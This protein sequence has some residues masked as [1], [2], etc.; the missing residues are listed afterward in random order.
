MASGIPAGYQLVRVPPP[1]VYVSVG[2]VKNH[3][4]IAEA[5][6]KKAATVGEVM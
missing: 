1:K 3:R 4:K 6:R 5:E 2:R